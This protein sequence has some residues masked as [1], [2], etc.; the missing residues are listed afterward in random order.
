M[1][2]FDER[3]K[4]IR[5][6]LSDTAVR[7]IGVVFQLGNKEQCQET[8]LV[9]KQGTMDAFCPKRILV[10]AKFDDRIKFLRAMA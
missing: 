2:S 9:R 1:I 5:N 7:L 3:Y 4:N 6:N 8:M 10:K